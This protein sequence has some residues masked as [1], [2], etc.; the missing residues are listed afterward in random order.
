MTRLDDHIEDRPGHFDVGHGR[1]VDE[2]FATTI[3]AHQ[4]LA[5]KVVQRLWRDQELAAPA[6]G[7]EGHESGGAGAQRPTTSRKASA[8]E[9]RRAPAFKVLKPAS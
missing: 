6:G 7:D 9:I 4:P 3:L 2:R 5:G 1:R 8:S